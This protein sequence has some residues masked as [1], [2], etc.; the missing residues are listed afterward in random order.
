MSNY[1]ERLDKVSDYANEFTEEE[2]VIPAEQVKDVI[3]EI[4]D[5]VNTIIGMLSDVNQHG[6][7]VVD[8]CLDDLKKLSADLY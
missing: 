6:F 2:L 4:G 7:G 3:S 5:E 8:E 1:N